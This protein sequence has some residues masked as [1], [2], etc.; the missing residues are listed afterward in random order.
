MKVILLQDVKS[1]GKQS[2]VLEVKTGYANNYLIPKKLAVVAN[3]KNMAELERQ[4]A[5]KRA[6]EA[7]IKQEA[8]DLKATLN[9]KVVKVFANG[10]TEGRLY[11]A[12]TSIDV[13]GAIKDQYTIEID[14]RKIVMDNIKSV[15]SYNIKIKL[16]PEV[17]CEMVVSVTIK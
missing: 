13:A 4:L 17:D 12:I 5:E 7:K 9:S 6:L 1:I 3:D 11:G 2:Q 15:G 8:I 16:H 10:G 14:K